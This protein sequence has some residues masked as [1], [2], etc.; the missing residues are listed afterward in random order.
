[1]IAFLFVA[2]LAVGQKEPSKKVSED[3]KRQFIEILKKLPTRGE[4]FTDEAITTAEP[5]TRVLFAL[6]EEDIGKDG[7]Y[8]FLALSAGLRQRKEPRKY[9]RD[10]FDSIAH[11]ILK[12]SW[13][14]TFFREPD[15]PPAV[16]AHL[17]K[18]LDSKDGAV[19]LEE[20][21]GPNFTDFRD[22][23]NRIDGAKR[24][25]RVELVKRHSVPDPDNG[26]LSAI[27]SVKFLSGGRAV[28]AAEVDQRGELRVFDID[29]ATIRRIPIPQPANF[30]S[31]YKF[32]HCFNDPSITASSAGDLFVVWQIR[33]NGDHGLA[34]LKQGSD[35]FTVAHSDKTLATHYVVPTANRK[36]WLIKGSPRFELFKIDERL[37]LIP[38]GSF[39]GRGHHTIQVADAKFIAKDVLHIF[40][41]DVLSLGNPLRVRCVDFDV[42]GNNWIH[43]REIARFDGFVSS[44]N[45]PVVLQFPD[46]S[47]HYVWRVDEGLGG[48]DGR[49]L[50]YQAESDGKTVKVSD[51][52]QARAI[53]VGDRIV[54][55]YSNEAA[56]NKVFFRVINRGSVGP[57]TELVIGEKREHNLSLTE[58][59]FGAD[60]NRIFCASSAM[61]DA[62]FEFRLADAAQPANAK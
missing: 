17:R 57:A 8:P 39:A 50:F 32:A 16:L 43:D 42:A 34:L 36:W 6:T 49:G 2:S 48:K 10:N 30:K 45:H 3:E 46:K 21:L 5:H 38:Y 22:A 33:G 35:S 61:K 18:T 51:S 56:P 59:A 55:A 52:H 9:A 28:S 58:M 4:F 7:V 13:A 29:K 26:V 53:A 37:S 12:L 19:L 11:P 62:I 24:R 25:V 20:M 60:G 40:W 54:V 23:F 41:G 14:L 1:M 47:L 31:P 44:A 27:Q 15:P